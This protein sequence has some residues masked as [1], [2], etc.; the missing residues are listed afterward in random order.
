VSAFLLDTSAILSGSVP[1]GDAA[2]S[3][4]TLGELRTGIFTAND[5]VTRATRNRRFRETC[6][7]FLAYDVDQNVAERFGEINAL[8]RLDRRLRDAADH[9]IIA[10]AAEHGL[11]LFTGDKKQGKLAEDLGLLVEYAG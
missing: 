4:I 1:A 5:P 6:K 3:V 10:T 9:L 7:S 11:T 2:I 8:A